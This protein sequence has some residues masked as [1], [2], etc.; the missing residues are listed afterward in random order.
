MPP[1]TPPCI[2]RRRRAGSGSRSAVGL[3]VALWLVLQLFASVLAPFVA[4]AVIAYALD[5]PT[6]YL[7]RSA[8]RAASRRC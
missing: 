8:C 2:R 3:L 6:T 5:P 4:A 1:P 7:T